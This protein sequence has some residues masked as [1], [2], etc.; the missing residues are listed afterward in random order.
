MDIKR[1]PP[2]K[3]KRYVM[4]GLGLAGIVAI[5]AWVVSLKPAAQSVDRSTLV[6][7]SVRRG[8]MIRSV[9]AA[10]TLA[11]EH[12]VLLTAIV[13]GRIDLLPVKPG[14][15][16]TPATTI[17]KLSSPDEELAVLNNEQTLS[18]E[19]SAQASLKDQIKQ[20]QMTEE[21]TIAGLQTQFNSATR[22]AS[23]DDSLVRLKLVAANDVANAHDQA[24][25]A[26]TRLDIETR[27]LSEMKTAAD[28]Q[29][30]LNDDQLQRLRAI[31]DAQH[32]RLV[33][34]DVKPEEGGVLQSLNNLELGQYVNAGQE[35]GRVAQPDK[36]KG[37]LQ[38]PDNQAKDIAIGQS[39]VIDLHN[40][41]TVRGHVMRADPAVQGGTVTVEVKIDDPLPQ[42]VRADQ[43]V[44]GTIE[45][46][47]LQNVL[48]VGRPIYG[49]AENTV[50]LFKLS[51]DGNEA[52]R[53][54]VKLGR[55]SVSYV[56][57]LSGLAV[58]DKIIVSD[59]SN[60]DNAQRVRI[61]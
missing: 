59:M 6:I 61:K 17:V 39:V 5:T 29:I 58:N 14:E 20:A 47:R 1:D 49:Q 50:G 16:V 24:A 21:A 38:V 52:T 13:A 42:G 33:S 30:R 43:S 8:N 4:I 18:Q 57:V 2:K 27:R 23:V 37:V 55:A 60:Y 31:V 10:G 41:S 45:I 34:M 22:Q 25:E 53:V 3:T 11:P 28:E 48:Y 46:E 51:P 35:L 56:E 32:Q 40:N 36:L 26:K 12:V 19:L 7:D 54:Q 44:D 9:N 15:T